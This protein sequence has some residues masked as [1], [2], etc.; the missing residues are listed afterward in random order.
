MCWF[1]GRGCSRKGPDGHEKNHDLPAQNPAQLV[2]TEHIGSEF[3]E[4]KA[5]LI[6][7]MASVVGRVQVRFS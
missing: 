1:G 4:K 5:G 6:S 2:C 3:G 7:Q